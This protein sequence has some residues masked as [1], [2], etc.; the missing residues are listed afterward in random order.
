MQDTRSTLRQSIK[1]ALSGFADVKVC[2]LYGSVV[3]GRLRPDSDLDVAVASDTVLD[4]ERKMALRS[5]FER[6]T[7]REVDLLDLQ[8]VSG[9][10]LHQALAR[11][12]VVM[13]RDHLLY[14]GIMKRMIF[15]QADM[16]PYYQ[17]MLEARRR[18]F[19]AS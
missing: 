15:N 18:A 7:G 4:H 14:A 11:G 5:K 2:L 10:I 8:S 16:M 17:R 1:G 19:V 3:Q 6:A 12:E 13:V 9:P